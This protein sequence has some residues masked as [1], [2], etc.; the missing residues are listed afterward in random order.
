MAT[1]QVNR[2]RD[3]SELF[4]HPSGDFASVVLTIDGHARELTPAAANDLM[5]DLGHAIGECR[6]NEPACDLPQRQGV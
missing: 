4:A 6:W 3:G 2:D 5:V 1:P